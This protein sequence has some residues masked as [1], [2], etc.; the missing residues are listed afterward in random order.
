MH[1]N[2][3][4]DLTRSF[5]SYLIDHTRCRSTRPTHRL[6][7][8]PEARPVLLSLICTWNNPERARAH[9]DR[10]ADKE[11]D[12]AHRAREFPLVPYTG[13]RRRSANGVD[14]RYLT[15]SHGRELLA[16]YYT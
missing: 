13:Q 3:A 15:V 12:N 16:L 11:L 5:L 14:A 9:G 2:L 1:Y 7:H 10:Q 8:R 4:Y 6:S